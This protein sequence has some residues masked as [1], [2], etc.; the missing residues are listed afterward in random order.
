MNC[1][2]VSFF[3]H[4]KRNGREIDMNLS[5]SRGIGR[6]SAMVTA[7]VIYHSIQFNSII[8]FNL[9]QNLTF[10]FLNESSTVPLIVQQFQVIN[11]CY[12]LPSSVLLPS[13]CPVDN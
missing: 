2:I 9:I 7:I 6:V 3:V 4:I 10:G 12:F 13:N 11:L 8:Q 5:T 1:S